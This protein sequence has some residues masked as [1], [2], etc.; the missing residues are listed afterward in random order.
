VTNQSLPPDVHDLVAEIGRKWG[1]T[2]IRDRIEVEVSPR[3]RRSLGRADLR[4]GRIVISPRACAD[5]TLLAEVLTH[6][7]AHV[8]AFDLV[9]DDEPPHGPTWANLVRAA[10][11]APRLRLPVADPHGAAITPGAAIIKPQAIF[12]HRCTICQSERTARRRVGTWRC[13]DCV[14]AGLDGL[15]SVTRRVSAP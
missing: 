4:A 9:G 7:L 14:A 12:A 8:V 11:Y 6:E 13:A 5:R 15:L 2:S 10:G 1:R 3:L